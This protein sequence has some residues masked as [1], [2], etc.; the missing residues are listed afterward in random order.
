MLSDEAVAVGQQS[1]HALLVVGG[2]G[3]G[4]GASGLDESVGL[5]DESNG[6]LGGEIRQG[7]CAFFECMHD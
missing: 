7:D 5:S 1:R 2:G 6:W 4:G 3:G